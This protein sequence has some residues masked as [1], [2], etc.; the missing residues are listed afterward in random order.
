[1]ILQG[2]AVVI[3]QP[4]K[5][6]NLIYGQGFSAFE[7]I[8][9]TPLI[10]PFLRPEEEHCRSGEDQVIVPTGEREGIVN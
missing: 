6:P 7:V 10:N 5:L 2:Q 9:F 4:G 3:P 8:S 1:M